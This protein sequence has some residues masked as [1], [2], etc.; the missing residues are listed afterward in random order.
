M[1]FSSKKAM[2]PLIATVLLIA[3]AVALGAM[4]MN[5]SAGVSPGDVVENQNCKDVS[6]TTVLPICYEDNQLLFAVKN[7]GD[8]RIDAVLLKITDAFGETKTTLRDSALIV[9]ELLE[10]KRPYAYD[11]GSIAIT[12]VPL[13]SGADGEL[14]SCESASITQETLSSC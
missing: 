3:F 4:I 8:E 9:G 14:E 11:D 10:S 13:V 12:F 1:V 6:L 5:W 7:D 2:S